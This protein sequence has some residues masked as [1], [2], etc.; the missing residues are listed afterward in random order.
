VVLPG[1]EARLPDAHPARLPAGLVLAEVKGTGDVL[2]DEQL[3]WQ[4]RLLRAGVAVE[5]WSVAPHPG[6]GKVLEDRR[7][8]GSGRDGPNLR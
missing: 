4:D 7:R 6:S 3:V 2:R 8:D 1:P 5:V